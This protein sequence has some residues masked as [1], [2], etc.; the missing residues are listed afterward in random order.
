MTPHSGRTGPRRLAGLLAAGLVLALAPAL[1]PGAPP[2]VAGDGTSDRDVEVVSG[3][4]GTWSIE[5]HGAPER[6][7]HERRKVGESVDGRTIWAY[8]LGEPSDVP[9]AGIKRVVLIATMHGDEQQSRVPLLA[10]KEGPALVGAD[11]WLVPTYNPD[12]LAAG[13]R[14]NARGVDLNR[15]YP[16]SWADLDGNY[17]SGSG[18]A[19]EP[20]TQAVMA[21]LREVRPHRILSFHQPLHG[22]DTDTK[23][24][25]W[26]RHVATTLKLPT[27][28]FDCGGVCHGTMTGWYNNRFD[29]SA[30]TVEFGAKPGQ[31]YL[32]E[33][34]PP[35]I[36]RVFG[37]RPGDYEWGVD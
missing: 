13:T 9:K 31:K 32:R 34:V 8:H 17:E 36:R 11:V 26:A 27:K 12:G 18:P 4:D 28:T 30:L 14:K 19:S 16:N 5:T 24:S 20:E 21:F 1:A 6:A 29:G 25:A 3:E 37:L 10:M 23:D 33:T 2:A 35:R 22:V 7:W 15:N